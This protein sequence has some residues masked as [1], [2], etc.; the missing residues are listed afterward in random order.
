M[1]PTMLLGRSAAG[2]IVDPGDKT[3]S[4]TVS[5]ISDPTTRPEIQFVLRST[6]S[7]FYYTEINAPGGTFHQSYDLMDPPQS[8]PL[9]NYEVMF[10][11]VSASGVY[12]ITGST[13]DVW[14]DCSTDPGFSFIEGDIS[15]PSDPSAVV[16]IT[17]RNATTLGEYFTDTVTM[18]L[19]RT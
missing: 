14:I 15:V 12:S 7:D 4:A 11:T 18:H 19:H 17:V 9:S 8:L 3:I 13:F 2:V 1:F 5:T 6:D 16:E 10:H